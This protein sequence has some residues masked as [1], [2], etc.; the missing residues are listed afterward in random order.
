MILRVDT[1]TQEAQMHAI[2]VIATLHLKLWT[3]EI[4]QSSGHTHRQTNNI[5]H[6]IFVGK[7][8]WCPDSWSEVCTDKRV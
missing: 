6:I 2:G 1:E 4:T 3:G 5:R 8:L 7:S